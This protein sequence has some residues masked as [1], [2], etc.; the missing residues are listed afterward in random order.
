MTCWLDR[1]VVLIDRGIERPSYFPRFQASLTFYSG[2]IPY[3]HFDSIPGIMLDQ[4]L[5]G[6]L[7]KI[8]IPV[9]PD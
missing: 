6:Y 1:D 8:T 4:K 9:R 5:S 7:A 2:H 3:T